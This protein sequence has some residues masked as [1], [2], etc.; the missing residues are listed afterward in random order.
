M[1]KPGG[2][3][4]LTPEMLKGTQK[5]GDGAVKMVPDSAMKK[6]PAG[7]KGEVMRFQNKTM[8][9]QKDSLKK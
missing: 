2:Q 1:A 9:A 8:A 4:A 3:I 6:L 5:A 7:A